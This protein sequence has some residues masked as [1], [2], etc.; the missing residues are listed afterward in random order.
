MNDCSVDL[1][2]RNAEI[3][4]HTSDTSHT[5]HK[6][7]PRSKA[8]YSKSKTPASSKKRKKDDSDN[9]NFHEEPV[10]KSRREAKTP[11]KTSKTPSKKVPLK[12]KSQTP[13]KSTKTPSKACKTPKSTNKVKAAKT[14]KSSVKRQVDSTDVASSKSADKDALTPRR[15]SGRQEQTPKTIERPSSARRRLITDAGTPTNRRLSSLRTQVFSSDGSGNISTSQEE[16]EKSSRG[17][18]R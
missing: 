15:R 6:E 8:L 18:I 10:K 5:S 3:M 4:S 9:E 17:R 12:S 11:S 16:F 7:T 13:N 1:D 2:G 14:P